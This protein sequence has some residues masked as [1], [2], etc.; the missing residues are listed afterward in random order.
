MP[1]SCGRHSFELAK[2]WVQ[3]S[4]SSTAD[5]LNLKAPPPPPTEP[6]TLETLNTHQLQ[7]PKRTSTKRTEDFMAP[8]MCVAWTRGLVSSG[9]ERSRYC[10][11][12]VRGLGLADVEL[13]LIKDILNQ[14]RKPQ[15]ILQVRSLKRQLE[16]PKKVNLGAWAT[17]QRGCFGQPQTLKA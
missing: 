6:E 17:S 2:S 9:L 3:A 12:L 13:V 16:N 11:L 4:V 14:P 15:Q 7:P 10:F 1:R 5:P 8:S